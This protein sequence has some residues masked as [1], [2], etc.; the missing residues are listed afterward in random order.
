MRTRY[1]EELRRLNDSMTC[2][3]RMI[4]S[5]IG[6]AAEALMRRDTALAKEII[7]RDDE[8]DGKE[9]EIEALCMKLFMKEQPVAGDLHTIIAALKMVT[10]M[11]RIGDHA[12]DIAETVIQTPDSSYDNLEH[13]R[14]MSEEI[15]GMLRQSIDAY[16][17]KDISKALAVIARD[18]MIDSLFD[19]VKKDLIHQIHANAERGEQIID[20]LMI[21]KYYERIGDHATNIAEWVIFS[22]TGKLKGRNEGYLRDNPEE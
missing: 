8:I 1:D 5:A 17:A 18:D 10:D 3:A 14:R 9:K 20:Y 15:A 12:S 7:A 16:T 11:E 4:E 21:A 6:T 2:M 13:I 19:F 22:I